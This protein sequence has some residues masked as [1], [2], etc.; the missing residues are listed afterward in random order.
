MCIRDST[1]HDLKYQYKWTLIVTAQFNEG[2]VV[3]YT[4]DGTTSDLGLIMHPQLTETYS[5]AEQGTVEKELISRCNGSPFPSA[6]THMLYTYDKTDKKNILWVSTDDDL[7][8]VETDYY[9]ILGHKEDA[10]VYLPGKLDIRSL[11]NTYQLSLIPISVCWR[12]PIRYA[13]MS[14][15]GRS[16]SAS[17]VTTIDAG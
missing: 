12:A 14:R 2:L 5:G 15:R 1:A 9:E 6:V 10:F 3:A 11:L 13:P 16:C 17:T 4:R 7:M 8:R